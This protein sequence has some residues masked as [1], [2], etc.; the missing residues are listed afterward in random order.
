MT[1]PNRPALPNRP[2]DVI[3]LSAYRAQLGR[4]R[5]LRRADA[6]ADAPDL[7]AAVRAL[8]GDELYYVLHEVGLREG[9]DLLACAT[10]E[11]LQVVLDFA[12]WERDQLD[13]DSLADWLE[14]IAAA[15]IESIGA[16]IAGIDTELVGLILRRTARIYDVSQEGPPEEPEGTFYP[17]P[18]RLF[19]LDVLPIGPAA[20]AAPDASGD[21][22]GVVIRIVDALYRTDQNLARRL[23]V[24]ARAESDA[25]LE[26]MS[27]RWR[28]ARMADL[29]FADY[30]EALEVYRELDPASVQL[31]EATAP[32]TG[33]AGGPVTEGAALRIPTALAER[34]RDTERSPFARAAQRLAAGDEIEGLRAALVTLTNRVLAADRVSPGDD[35]AVPAVLERL[36]AT[37][38]IAIDRVAPGDDD[39]GAQALRTIPL[40]QLFRLGVTLIGK[41]RRLG[42]A[43][44]REGPFGPRGWALAEPD[45]AVVLTAVTRLRSMFPR[46]LDTPPTAG[47]RPF[48]SLADLARAAAAIERAAVAQAMLRGLGV[49][50]ADIATDGELL[51]AAAI[52]DAAL[53]VGLLART[54]LVGRLAGPLPGR[55]TPFA[56]LVP[57][58][59]AAFEAMLLQTRGG[60][61]RL[62]PALA[63]RATDILT[64]AT[65]PAL[66]V[67]G[68][69]VTAR[70]LASLAPLEPV[71]VR[72]VPATK[73]PARA[74]ARPSAKPTAKPK[75]TAKTKTKTKT[76]PKATTRPKAKAIAKPKT[77]TKPKPK[78]KV[79]AK[80]KATT[81]PKAKVKV[82]A[83]ERAKMKPRG[84]RLSTNSQP[85]TNCR[86][87]KFGPAEV[88]DARRV[89]A[90]VVGQRAIL[91]WRWLRAWNCLGRRLSALP[92][93]RETQESSSSQARCRP[94]GQRNLAA[95]G[96]PAKSRS[97]EMR[98]ALA[99]DAR[100][101][102]RGS[103]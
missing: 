49:T 100:R 32:A 102:A 31:G 71:L 60:P 95:H 7:A 73:P 38:D 90:P 72:R 85:R 70:W 89:R 42:L 2:A 79:K 17:T 41:L 47:E 43:L 87:F 84:K 96:R 64:A 51:G 24:G 65:P 26:E 11:Q 27:Y 8:P 35:E 77:S 1:S 39:R 40:V 88:V 82:K 91:I 10:A 57:S 50:P 78:A 63:A 5:R 45:D 23:L 28:Q 67:A 75:A 53:D 14:A 12:L 103:F 37:L 99:G 36:A 86:S 94:I 3:A 74:E 29:G 33:A 13:P 6:L 81:K 22:A 15:P 48:R 20:D 25:E 21:C 59:V 58:D 4:G 52:D 62:S 66:A 54:A 9:G 93:S 92:A 55:E 83:T 98:C 30:Y 80:P 46:L 18:D 101:R 68:Q 69:A 44:R 34:M 61:P 76:K 19:V 56:A 16:W 97:Q